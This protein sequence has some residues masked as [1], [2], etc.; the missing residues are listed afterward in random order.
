M[1]EKR[2][3]ILNFIASDTRFQDDLPEYWIVTEYYEKGS[4]HDFLKSN[5]LS[6][7][8]LLKVSKG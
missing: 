7:D 8:Q 5:I 4:L 6:L 1:E 3:Y 2:P